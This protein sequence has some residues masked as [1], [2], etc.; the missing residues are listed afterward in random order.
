MF[1]GLNYGKLTLGQCR[2]LQYKQKK[3]KT[4]IFP[5]FIE[6]RQNINYILTELLHRTLQLGN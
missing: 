3:D 6:I 1:T 2:K 4:N 5:S